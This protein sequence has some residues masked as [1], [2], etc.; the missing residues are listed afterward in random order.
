M[1]NTAQLTTPTDHGQLEG[2]TTREETIAWAHYCLAN[3]QRDGNPDGEADALATLATCNPEPAPRVSTT[4]RI[5]AAL[6]HSGT[7]GK[8]IAYRLLSP[9]ESTENVYAVAVLC[10]ASAPGLR[11]R[12]VA[13]DL[14][15]PS[16][17]HDVSESSR[18]DYR[19]GKTPTSGD[20]DVA[21]NAAF[22]A[23]RGFGA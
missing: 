3:A 10:N 11:L 22:A 1:T 6:E 23:Y 12:V 13:L 15:S 20:A 17:G 9:A 21:L 19:L 7:V 14:D 2:P 4:D 5:I 16:T 8:P 18:R